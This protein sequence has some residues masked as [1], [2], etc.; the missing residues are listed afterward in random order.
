MDLNDFMKALEEERPHWFIDFATKEEL[1]NCIAPNTNILDIVRLSH[2]VANRLFV[3]ARATH[4]FL[5]KEANH[6]IL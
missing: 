5:R 1:I 3:C 4:N 2:E 6:E